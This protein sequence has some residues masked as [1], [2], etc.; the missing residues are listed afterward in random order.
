MSS[1]ESDGGDVADLRER[2]ARRI[3][4]EVF[5][6]WCGATPKLNS[7]P[8]EQP[9]PPLN[10]AL[11]DKIVDRRRPPGPIEFGTGFLPVHK[12]AAEWGPLTPGGTIVVPANWS[13]FGKPY[14]GKVDHTY[15]VYVGR[16]DHAGRLGAAAR[17][18]R[19]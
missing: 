5:A 6:G 10:F 2:I 14:A 9:S 3:L 12:G 19:H 16:L 15:E 4:A 13:G 1:S 8:P 7:G 17:S 11:S 18:R